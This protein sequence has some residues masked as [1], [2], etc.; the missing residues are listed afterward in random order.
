MLWAIAG[1]LLLISVFLIARPLLRVPANGPDRRADYDVAVFKDQLAELEE[2]RAQGLIGDAAA[3]AAKLEIQ[4][5]LLAATQA[6]HP[7]S[8]PLAARPRRLLA[9]AA[10][11]AIPLGAIT[12][13]LAMGRPGMPDQPYIDRL[14]LRLGTTVEAAQHQENEVARLTTKLAADPKDEAAWRDLGRAQRALGRHGDAADSLRHALIN[15]GRDHE[16]IAEMAESMVIA[17]QG[18][19]TAEARRAFDTVLLASPNHPKAL[20][21]LGMERMQ[22]NDAQ[23]ALKYWKRLEANSPAD[24]AW[25]PMIRQRIAEAE[26][27]A[28]GKA[29]DSATGSAPNIA[30]MVGKLEQHLKE[31]PQDVQGW[32]MLGRS[33]A[34]LGELDKAKDAYGQAMRLSPEDLEL[35]QSYAVMLYETARAKDPKAK[36]PPEAAQ[37]MK[38]VLDKD[39]HALDALFVSGQAALDRG[40]KSEA[41]ALWSRVLEQLEPGGADYNDLKKMVDGL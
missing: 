10:I 4:R 40:D 29:P 36:V 14:A 15:G 5:R 26:A 22:A 27:A 39:P 25:L 23:G 12:L 2:E 30:A 13:Y 19:V 11:A 21:Y 38:Q 24:A 28:S 34:V 31:N 8:H 41:K 6:R 35:K 18:E 17:G 7:E 37:L 33:Y 32:S 9:L 20:Y 1:L 16:L 3:E